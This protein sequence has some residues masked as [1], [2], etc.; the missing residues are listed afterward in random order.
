MDMR[1]PMVNFMLVGITRSRDDV[2]IGKVQGYLEAHLTLNGLKKYIDDGKVPGNPDILYLVTGMG[3]HH[4]TFPE[5]PWEAGYLMSYVDGGLKRYRPSP[6]SVKAMQEVYRKLPPDCI[7]VHTKTNYMTKYKQYPGQTVRELYFCKKRVKK[8]ELKLYV[9]KADMETEEAP[10]QVRYF[11]KN[12]A[13]SLRGTLSQ[14]QPNHQQQRTTTQGCT[15]MTVLKIIVPVIVLLFLAVAIISVYFF[16]RI[17]KLS[18]SRQELEELPN[19][20]NLTLVDIGPDHFTISWVPPL[21]NFDYYWLE[22]YHIGSN[23][24]SHALYRPGSCGNGTIIHRDQTELTCYA[25]TA[26][27]NLTIALH[28][29][30]KGTFDLTSTGATLRGIFMPGKDLPEV[31]NLTLSAMTSDSVTLSW[32]RPEG[33]FDQYVVMATKGNQG[34]DTQHDASVGSCGNARILDTT[35]TSVTCENIQA[36]DVSLTVQTR[37]LR[38][39]V[40]TS[41]GVTLQGILMSKK[42]ESDVSETWVD[43]EYS[44]YGKMCALVSSSAKCGDHVR[45]SPPAAVEITP[46]SSELPNVKNLT[47][48][49]I[50]PDHFTMSWVPPLVD[51]DYY[52][53]EVYHIGSNGDIHAPYRLGSCHNGTIIHRDQRELTC[54]A[55]TACTNLTIALHT[56]VKGTLDLTSTGATL[57]GIFMPGKDLPEVVNL[58][59]AA[60]TSDSVT[61]SWQRPKGCFDQYVVMATEGNQGLDTQHD[62]VGSC[63]NAR[64]V[65]AAQ[66][67]I[68]CENIQA[69]DVSIT[70]QTRRLRPSVLTSQGVTLQGIRMPIKD[71]PEVVNLTLASMSKDS[72]TVSWQRPKGCFDHYVVKTTAGS[73][74]LGMGYDLSVGS[75]G[76]ERL[77]GPTETSITCD[78]IEACSI[79]VTV[80]T[81]RSQPLLLTSQGVQLQEILMSKR[82]PPEVV[83]LT[84]ASMSK[85][86]VTVSWQRPKG[87]FDHY[88]VKTTAG[89]PTLGMGY[90]LSVGSC[91]NER[92]IGPTETSIT[93]DEI[94]ACSISVTVQTR[95]SQPLLLTSQGVQ[96]QEILMSKKDL[97]EVMNLT[98]AAT[99]TG[100]VTLSWQRP[101]GCFDQYVVKATAENHRMGSYQDL[102]A[103]SCGNESILDSAETSVTCEG[104]SA[105]SVNIMVRTRRSGPL[106]LT[107]QG[108]TLHG[109]MPKI[110]KA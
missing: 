53:L 10:I 42:S 30:V 18:N 58:T 86:S 39:S 62:S 48:V 78:E 22:V 93:C 88:V 72:V 102:N 92:L 103:G 9:R 37:R 75:C 32:Q 50:G 12:D 82:D 59:L 21:V 97:P 46:P 1:K 57:Q 16:K 34:L 54:Y 45:R 106:A 35:Q 38:P 79:S 105:C 52:W 24:N 99:S 47:L 109:V 13:V 68:T 11:P 80:Q 76:N 60:M 66:T 20:K 71:P 64:I 83:N 36:C 87:C 110:G 107:S 94:E 63:G 61:L 4:D 91:G 27:T 51:F 101:K 8:P 96:L 100:S 17:D 19:V 6:C 3:A 73:P 104:I 69:C 33:C 98:L 15:P 49:N 95:R 2:F 70:V 81:R 108:V 89:S 56:Q 67:S 84:L 77:I 41:Q 5:C 44:W 65:D 90:D 26:C 23:G 43:L 7:Q 31:V 29:Q 28:T 14:Q 85:D 55:F 40:L 25:F 74:T